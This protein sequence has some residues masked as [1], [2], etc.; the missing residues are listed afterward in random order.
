M[1]PRDAAPRLDKNLVL[2]GGRGSG[3]SSI[4]K[5]LLRMNKHFILLPLDALIRYEAGGITIPEIVAREGWAGFREREFQVVQKVG[6]FEGSVLAD[7]GGGVV[8]DL[9]AAGDECFSERKV[10]ALRRHGLV[11]YLQRDTEYLL[12]RIA[13][14]GSRPPLSEAE[15]FAEI[16]ARRDPWYRKAAD[17]ILECGRLDKDEIADRL[18]AWF[19]DALRMAARS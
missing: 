10:A 1:P 5:R 7:C 15:S 8:V 11:V 13:G 14:D 9:D 3:K 12:R 17:H 16:M 18:L 6:A 19:Y 4:A 2:I